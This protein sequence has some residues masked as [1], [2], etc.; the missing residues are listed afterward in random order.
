MTYF[1]ILLCFPILVYICCFVNI[2]NINVILLGAKIDVFIDG[3]IINVIIITIVTE[4][5]TPHRSSNQLQREVYWV[6]CDVVISK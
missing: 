3:V 6:R 2:I 5:Q 4:A 1:V